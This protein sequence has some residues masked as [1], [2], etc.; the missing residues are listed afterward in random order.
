MWVVHIGLSSS[1]S[2]QSVEFHC[3]LF[4]LYKNIYSS[5]I[6]IWRVSQN[7][8]ENHNAFFLRY[9]KMLLNKESL[10]KKTS[11]NY[12]YGDIGLPP[13]NLLRITRTDLKKWAVYVLGFYLDISCSFCLFYF[14]YVAVFTTYALWLLIFLLCSGAHYFQRQ[15]AK[16]KMVERADK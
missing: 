8:R 5:F 11:K 16:R 2:E 4:L 10:P 13:S 1:D 6:C 15:S 3:H 12:I 14:V 9:W 7:W